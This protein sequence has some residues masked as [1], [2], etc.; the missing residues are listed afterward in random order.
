MSAEEVVRFV[1]DMKT[2]ADL[3]E[4][5]TE[6]AGSLPKIVA[7]ASEKGYVFTVEEAN[8]FL[9]GAQGAELQD[10]QL[11]AVA[12]GKSHGHTTPGNLSPH[13]TAGYTQ[14]VAAVGGIVVV[15]AAVVVT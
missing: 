13:V 9:A 5:V 4:I 3:A 11:D 12:G 1:A 8:E 10:A 14:V 6:G 7:L 2:N 15:A